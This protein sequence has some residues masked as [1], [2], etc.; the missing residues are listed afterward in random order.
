MVIITISSLSSL[1]S[2][3]TGAL[4]LI[5]YG[6]KLGHF[7]FYIIAAVLGVF[8]LREQRRR[9][10]TQRKAFVVIFLSTLVFGIILELLQYS[11]TTSRE[12]E[13]LDAIANGVGSLMGIFATKFIFSKR[14][15]LSWE[16]DTL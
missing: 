16:G 14:G 11:L 10:L 7:A 6:D 2:I 1:S 5:P 3:D 9:R 4:R 8:F 15:F 13:L 12:G